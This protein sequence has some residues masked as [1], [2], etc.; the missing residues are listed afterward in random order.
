MHGRPVACLRVDGLPYDALDVRAATDPNPTSGP[1]PGEYVQHHVYRPGAVPAVV[2]NVV[3]P[4]GGKDLA[5]LVADSFDRG[6]CG[7]R[8]Q[9]FAARS[10][11]AHRVVELVEQGHTGGDVQCDD[12]LV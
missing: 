8:V 1:S 4:E 6:G 5:A 3:I 9:I 12:G 2:V 7:L 10:K 11:G